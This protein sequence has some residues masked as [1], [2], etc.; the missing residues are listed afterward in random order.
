ML[1]LVASIFLTAMRFHAGGRTNKILLIDL[2]D[3]IHAHRQP[4]GG[5]G[6]F[7][8][9]RSAPRNLIMDRTGPAML[10]LC[11]GA[12]VFPLGRWLAPPEWF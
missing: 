11:S 8:K 6:C 7:N 5:A 2:R 12:S 10:I 3:L 9:S 1:L 4:P